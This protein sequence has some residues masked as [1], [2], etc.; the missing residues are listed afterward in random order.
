MN[1]PVCEDRM[2]EV[3]RNG[4]TLDVC[5]SCKGVWLDKG[6]L[7]KLL[8]LSVSETTKTEMSSSRPEAA[9]PYDKRDEH[10]REYREYD[11][12]NDRREGGERGYGE[13]KRKGSWLG[14][15]LGGLGG[16]D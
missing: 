9:R 8:E 15:I 16:D 14:D 10:S 12:D 6:E 2:K 1:C 11:K 5:P 13:R 3:D 7:E 4:V